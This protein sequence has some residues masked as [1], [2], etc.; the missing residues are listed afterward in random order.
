NGGACVAAFAS[1][2]FGGQAGS[3]SRQS[4]RWL[5][6]NQSG[7]ATYL[8]ANERGGEQELFTP[9]VACDEV[10]AERDEYRDHLA[11]R[12]TFASGSSVFHIRAERSGRD[13]D[14][15]GEGC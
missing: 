12:V 14:V 8:K 7:W 3:V 1:A 2:R 15:G 13:D 4:G 9:F 5:S 6:W 11:G 10:R